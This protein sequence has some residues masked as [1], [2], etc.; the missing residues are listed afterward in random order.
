MILCEC[1][2]INSCTFCGAA[3]GQSVNS[4]KSGCDETK[5][6]R[7]RER[8]NWTG[9]VKHDVVV[10]WLIGVVVLS[11][12]GGRRP[13]TAAGAAVAAVGQGAPR[14]GSG[15]GGGS[16]RRDGHDTQL[17]A[18][19]V[20]REDVDEAAALVADGRRRGA[21]RRLADRREHA[22]GARL[23]R[24]WWRRSHGSVRAGVLRSA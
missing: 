12:G 21:A 9:V 19:G 13:P 4:P 1:G 5:R 11:T 8:G 24:P 16:P 15:G 18:V 20:G 6:E 17:D 10:R 23:G 3:F 22:T 7:K 2:T 14:S